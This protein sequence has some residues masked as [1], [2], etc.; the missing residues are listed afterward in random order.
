MGSFS[1]CYCDTG[2]IRID[3]DGCPVPKRSQRLLYRQPAYVLIPKEFGGG[4]IFEAS[5]PDY[6][7]FGGIDIYD[8][9]A[10][11]NRAWI[12][13]HPEWKRPYDVLYESRYPE[14]PAK[15]IS[16]MS[17]YPFF[18]DL[19]LSRKEVVERWR[20]SRPLD[21][22]YWLEYREIGIAIA[23]QD[24]DNEALPFP[25]KVARFKESVYENYPASYGDP[26]QGCD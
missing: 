5:Y 3:R 17:W 1:W 21:S 18:S 23:C 24:E 7:R 11:W 20:D 2:A 9:V 10:D 6:G 26:G 13:S 4:H 12:A 16:A 14:D 22:N 25:I 8:L 19:S 15:P